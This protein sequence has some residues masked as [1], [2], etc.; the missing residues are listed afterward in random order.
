MIPATRLMVAAALA[1]SLL[2]LT[3]ARADGQQIPGQFIVELK[4]GVDRDAFLG[5][6]G[7]GQLRRYT[8][9]HGFAARLPAPLLTRLQEDPRVAAMRPDMVVSALARA[10]AAGPV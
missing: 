3:G 9:I 1:L 7:I 4:P 8:I 5:L 10:A 2:F 6:H